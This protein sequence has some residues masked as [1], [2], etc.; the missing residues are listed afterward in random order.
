MERH[1]ADWPGNPFYGS[2]GFHQRSGHQSLLLRGI[3]GMRTE[4]LSDEKE[5]VVVVVVVVVVVAVAV[6]VAVAV[7]GG[8]GGPGAKVVEGRANLQ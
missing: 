3:A 4:P 7:F 6:A 2:G 8:G 5:M 1:G